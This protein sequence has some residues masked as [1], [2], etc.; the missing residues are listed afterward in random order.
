[1]IHGQAPDVDKLVGLLE[2]SVPRDRIVIAD[3]GA[4]IGTHAGPRCIGVAFQ[5]GK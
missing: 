2:P 5:V 4:V 1:V 3:L